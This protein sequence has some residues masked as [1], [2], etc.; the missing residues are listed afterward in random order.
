M[1]LIRRV[2]N[3]AQHATSKRAQQGAYRQ[4]TECFDLRMGAYPM[5]Q[6]CLKAQETQR[7]L[8]VRIFQACQ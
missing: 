7:L 6:E 5:A 3:A 4:L 2:A 1:I 8:F